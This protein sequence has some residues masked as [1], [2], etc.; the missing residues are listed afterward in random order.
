MPLFCYFEERK[1]ELLY[2][3]IKSS[4]GIKLKTTL[5]WLINKTRLEKRLE[6]RNGKRS[7]IIIIVRNE[8]DISK[9]CAKRLRFGLAPKV[10]EKYSEVGSSSICMTYSRIGHNQLGRCNKSLENCVIYTKSHKLKNYRYSITQY[11]V[12]T[13]KICIFIVFIYINYKGNYQVIIFIYLVM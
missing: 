2:Q 11:L 7:A 1:I 9:L 6:V 5:C 10:D 12:K 13:K 4:T 3:Q 8:A